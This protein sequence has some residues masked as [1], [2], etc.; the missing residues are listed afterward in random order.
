MVFYLYSPYEDLTMMTLLIVI[1]SAVGVCSCSVGVVA[2]FVY[3]RAKRRLAEDKPGDDED[4]EHAIEMQLLDYTEQKND[5]DKKLLEDH[6]AD[7][8]PVQAEN[9]SRVFPN[10][11]LD[12]AG[13]PTISR[14]TKHLPALMLNDQYK[15]TR[16]IFKENAEESP[17]RQRRLTSSSFQL[18][19]TPFNSIYQP[20][21]DQ[22][23]KEIAEAHESQEYSKEE[24][25]PEKNG[26][27]NEISSPSR[28]ILPTRPQPIIHKFRKPKKK[29]SRIRKLLKL[30][31]R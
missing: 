25:S 24:S 2:Y 21:I 18:A 28:D 29:S 27:L 23:T 16:P 3:R 20:V 14:K 10:Q 22:Q 13:K 9:D 6:R 26:S 11:V 7:Q 31:Q 19:R 4:N 30:I 17:S 5:L 15:P 8:Q 12:T 1:I